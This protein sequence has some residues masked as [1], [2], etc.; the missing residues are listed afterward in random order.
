MIQCFSRKRGQTV[1]EQGLCPVSVSLVLVLGCLWS[2]LTPDYLLP[3]RDRV[4][5][6]QVMS[7]QPQT[8]SYHLLS[9]DSWYLLQNDFSR[10]RCGWSLWYKMSGINTYERTGKEAV[11]CREVGR[12]SKALEGSLCFS[13]EV[14]CVGLK[15]PDFT[16]LPHLVTRQGLQQG[17]CPPWTCIFT[18][19]SPALYMQTQVPCAS[20]NQLL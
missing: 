6:P 10:S 1:L 5:H 12:P 2:F 15:R 9:H 13:S 7:E 19:T 20:G 11:L 3:H 8:P 17:G 4:L 18:F 16:L 14:F